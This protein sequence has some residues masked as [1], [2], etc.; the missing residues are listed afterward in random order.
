[1]TL[2]MKNSVRFK[3]K[4]IS[5]GMGNNMCIW[6]LQGGTCSLHVASD[7]D[8]SRAS[9]MHDPTGGTCV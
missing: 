1:M 4:S 8:A 7:E 5:E 6:I 3:L 2:R 9:S